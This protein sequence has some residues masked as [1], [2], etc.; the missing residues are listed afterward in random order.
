MQYPVNTPFLINYFIYL[1][2]RNQ[3]VRD[4]TREGR[5]S[6]GCVTVM[7]GGQVTAVSVTRGD[8][9]R[10]HVGQRRGKS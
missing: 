1:Q 4:V 9:R 6:V 2:F 8:Q 10:K 5:T 3:T 7:R